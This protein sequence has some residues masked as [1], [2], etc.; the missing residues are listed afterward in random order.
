MLTLTRRLAPLAAVLALAACGGSD[1]GQDSTTRAPSPTPSPSC[2]SR[3]A[4]A[5]MPLDTRLRQLLFAGVFTG[6]PDPMAS[7]TAA[8]NAGVGGIN[9]LGNDPEVYANGELADVT[10]AGGAMPPFLAVDQ[11]GGRVQ[12]LRDLIGSQPSAREMGATLSSI[13]VEQLAATTGAAMADLGLTMD[14]APVADVS[15]QPDDAVIGDRAFSDDPEQVAVYAGAYADGLRAEGIIP[16]LKHFPGIGSASGNTDF[17]PATSPPL[18]ELQQSDLLPYERLLV[19]EPV[20]VMMGTAVVPGLTDGEPAG[21][22]AAAVDLLRDDLGFDGV[23]MTDSLSGAA[24]ESL[25]SLPEAA[26]RAL[27]AGVDM[28]L[29]DSSGEIQSIVD[30]LTEAVES[31]RLA[32]ERV[33]E[34]VARVLALKG[35]DACELTA[36]Q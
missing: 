15:D 10:A 30:R 23:V 35:I 20:A 8:V 14:L 31:G 3:D 2:Q 36:E 32:E 13:G 29:W 26:E 1:T 27:L 22:S 6:E 33:N 19:S 4:V 16:V 21:L 12:R 9:F 18:A 5:D 34:A 7:A 17:E 11:E 25:Y 24:V 28:V